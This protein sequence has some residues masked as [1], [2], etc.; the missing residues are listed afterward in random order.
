MLKFAPTATTRYGLAVAAVVAAVIAR[1]VLDPWLGGSLPFATLFLAVLVV[2]HRAGRGPALLAT[3]LGGLGAASYLIA[4]FGSALVDG[5]ENR[6]GLLVYAFVGTGIALLGGALHEARRRAEESLELADRRRQELQVTLDSIGDG[7]L[8]TDAEGRVVSLNPAAE[9]LTGWRSA[10]AV[11]QT[12]ESVFRIVNEA[13]R[14]PVDNPTLR[15]LRE[16]TI[17]GLSNHTNLLARDGV[18]R[19]IDDSA[20][21]I[22][23]RAGRVS[24]AV[25]VFRDIGEARRAEA[26][27]CRAGDRALAIL[28]SITDG[29]CALDLD[30]RFTFINRQAESLLGTSAAALI[31]RNYWEAYPSLVGSELE[32]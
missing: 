11:G 14:T 20:A 17:V 29:F 19:P 16:G 30:W 3:A 9:K 4:P 26:E 15:V 23:D 18:E 27:V 28:G 25:L 31:G 32:R 2:A 8:V 13:T 1:R 6:A 5:S 12:L 7:V 21:P 24:G 10:E 22:R